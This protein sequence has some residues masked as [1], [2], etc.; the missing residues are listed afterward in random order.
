M[1]NCKRFELEDKERGGRNTMALLVS[2]VLGCGGAQ[3]RTI[4]S[5]RQTR[6]RDGPSTTAS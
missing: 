2:V 3:Q 5:Q 4:V 1:A 6:I